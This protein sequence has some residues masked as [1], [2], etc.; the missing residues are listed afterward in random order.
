MKITLVNAVLTSIT[1]YAL[2]K[3]R[4]PKGILNKLD[5]YKRQFL[6]QG[7]GDNK[8]KPVLINW[9]GSHCQGI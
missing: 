6:W 3:Y 1:L 9:T 2:S 8:Q 4:I 5:R 7:Y